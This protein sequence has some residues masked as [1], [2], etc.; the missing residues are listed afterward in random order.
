MC[1]KA[2][3]P[4]SA[5]SK[6]YNSDYIKASSSLLNRLLSP[7]KL[8]SF[9]AVCTV[10]YLAVKGNCLPCLQLALCKSVDQLMSGLGGPRAKLRSLIWLISQSTKRNLT[11]LGGRTVTIRTTLH[12]IFIVWKYTHARTRTHTHTHTHARTHTHIHTHTHIQSLWH[13][14][15]LRLLSHVFCVIC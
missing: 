12:V 3:L 9:N 4:F 15:D 2:V 6:T 1:I 5:C 11:W 7:H 13:N 10:L 8:F 14:H